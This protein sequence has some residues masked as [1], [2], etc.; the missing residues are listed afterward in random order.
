MVPI[1]DEEDRPR[2]G[3]IPAPRVW[4]QEQV[5]A[6]S[7]FALVEALYRAGHAPRYAYAAYTGT[8]YAW[9]TTLI[10]TWEPCRRWH[11]C[12]PFIQACRLTLTPSDDTGDWWDLWPAGGAQHLMR[13]RVPWD[14]VP[15]VLCELR[16]LYTPPVPT[17]RDTHEGDDY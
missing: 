2:A 11:H 3:E 1:H 6:L 9:L 13:Q 4:T 15:R 10:S 5:Q 14:Q 16:L 7:E 12:A 8:E 17:P